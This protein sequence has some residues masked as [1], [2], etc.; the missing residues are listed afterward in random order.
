V[1][2]VLDF[3]LVGRWENVIVNKFSIVYMEI[4]LLDFYTDWCGPCKQQEPILEEI[5]EEYEE[6]VSIKKIDVESNHEKANEFN[7]KSVPTLILLS[8]KE[9]Q[10]RFVGLQSYDVLEEEIENLLP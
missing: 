5:Q 2:G 7:V 6:E 3:F 10:E 1:W 9:V 4:E 8:D